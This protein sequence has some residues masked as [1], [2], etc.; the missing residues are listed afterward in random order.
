LQTLKSKAGETAQKI[1]KRILEMCLRIQFY[2]YS[3]NVSGL[4]IFFK[5]VKI[6]VAYSMGNISAE[7]SE[8]QE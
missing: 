2:I 7:D 8:Q 1:K 4:V 5:K 6:V 3:I